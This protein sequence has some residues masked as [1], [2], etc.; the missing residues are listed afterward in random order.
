M[1]KDLFSL[2]LFHEAIDGMLPLDET[3]LPRVLCDSDDLPLDVVD[4]ALSTALGRPLGR[5]VVDLGQAPGRSSAAG[6]CCCG[7]GGGGGGVVVV[8]GD[9]KDLGEKE[10]WRSRSSDRKDGMSTFFNM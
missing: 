4:M 2:S 9:D 5:G 7:G 1:S 10:F 6:V 8:G 3:V